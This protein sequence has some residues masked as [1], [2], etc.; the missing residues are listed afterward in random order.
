MGDSKTQLVEQG[1]G[2]WCF[3]VLDPEENNPF[4]SENGELPDPTYDVLECYHPVDVDINDKGEAYAW[5]YYDYEDTEKMI[6]M[7]GKRYVPM[8]QVYL[9]PLPGFVDIRKTEAEIP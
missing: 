2:Y 9:K 7:E 1:R 4:I 3:R 6:E 5:F 8:D